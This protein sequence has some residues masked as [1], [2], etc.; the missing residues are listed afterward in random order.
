MRYRLLGRTGL[1]VSEL[2][3][4]VMS[5]GA[6][7]EWGEVCSQNEEEANRFVA[8]A[9][10]LGVNLFDTAEAYSDGE[11]ERILGRAL[12]CRRKDVL[13]ATKASG[14]AEAQ[15][16]RFGLSRLRIMQA[17]EGSLS[18][19]NTDYLDL[20]QIHVHDPLTPI[21]ETLRVLED[22]VRM[23]KVRYIGCANQF[24]WQVMQAVGIAAAR[25]YTR[26]EAVQAYY[27]V[28]GRDIER[29]T[30]PL[31]IDQKIG[32][33]VWSPLAGGFLTEKFATGIG[34]PE[35]RRARFNFP[36]VDK[37]RALRCIF[38]MRDIAAAHQCTVAG[39]ALA[40]LLHQ[41]VV[42]SVIIGARTMEQ[43]EENL[44]ATGVC[45]SSEELARID[46][47]S[48]LPREYP[49]WLMQHIVDRGKRLTSAKP[50][51]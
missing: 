33:L 36:P 18:R 10:E 41:D 28:A 12:G 39:I 2:S 40:W 42:T 7:G 45:L 22:V 17:V 47:A 34:P 31:L 6:A 9:L 21:E 38:V 15:S 49:G 35:S 27:S 1:F 44:Q 14:R 24:A 23:G 29:E 37:D 8:R 32:L 13:I 19:L 4:G 20:Y 26:F 51:G 48:S 50:A 3:L 16:N 25:N 5:F 43:L 30:I 46:E 11:S